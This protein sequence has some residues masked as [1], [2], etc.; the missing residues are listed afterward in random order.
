MGGPCPK[1]N[2]E[3]VVARFV[4]RNAQQLIFFIFLT[5]PDSLHE[6]ETPLSFD[7]GQA[8]PDFSKNCL[9][10]FTQFLENVYRESLYFSED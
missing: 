1:S 5:S 4:T 8:Y 7:F 6:G 2:G 10:P 3:I 9:V